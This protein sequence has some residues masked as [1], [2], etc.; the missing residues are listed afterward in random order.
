MTFLGENSET[1]TRVRFAGP[2]DAR[3]IGRLYVRAYTPNKTGTASDHYPFPQI[4][5][6]DRVSDLIMS[7]T[8]IWV[9]A[10]KQDGTIV[11]SAAAVR[12]IGAR[13]DR[14]AEIFGVVV[15][16]GCRRGGV[17]STLLQKLK[18]DLERSSEFILCE[19]RT[20]EAGG[21]KAARN[22]GFQPGWLR[23]ICPFNASRFRVNGAHRVLELER[24][25]TPS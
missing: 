16:Q 25:D 9:V 18:G 7:G 11:G 23:T 24:D 19:A 6:E 13:P 3:A 21:W 1:S 2:A 20:A 8:V 22:A 10:E 15:D 14:I 4:M 17:G 5:E 12:N